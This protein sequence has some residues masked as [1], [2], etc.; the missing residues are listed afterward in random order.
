MVCYSK[1]SRRE[2]ERAFICHSNVP[3]AFKTPPTQIRLTRPTDIGRWRSDARVWPYWRPFVL[4]KSAILMRGIR[5][6]AKKTKVDVLVWQRP[7]VGDI[8][9]HRQSAT[10]YWRKKKAIRLIHSTQRT[11]YLSVKSIHICWLVVSHS[12]LT[13]YS[14][15]SDIS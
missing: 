12:A 5:P 9:P 1:R 7:H 2:R 6:F 13:I 3:R 11:E 4:D 10:F 15:A 14:I 8:L